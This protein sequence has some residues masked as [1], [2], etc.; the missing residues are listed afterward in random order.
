MCISVSI[1]GHNIRYIALF[2]ALYNIC[3]HRW[4]Q[5][6][7]YS[8]IPCSVQC[9]ISVSIGGHNIRYKL[10]L[11]NYL[12][13]ITEFFNIHFGQQLKIKI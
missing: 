9:T 2:H 5:Y 11:K 8:L 12:A 4:A 6:P 13:V 7:L 10:I 1:G 3:E